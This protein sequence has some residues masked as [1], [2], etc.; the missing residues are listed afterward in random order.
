MKQI[1]AKMSENSLRARINYRDRID[2]LRSRV[3]LLT[4]KDKLL[5]TMCLE[6]GNSFRQLAQLTGVT[7]G[8]ISRRVQKITRRLMDGEYIACLRNR[9]KFTKAEL[10]IAKDYFLIG[11]SIKKITEKR[12]Y[13]YY[14]IRKAIKK[15]QALVNN[16]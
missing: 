15:I 13:T 3:S 10:D 9:D 6:H 5:M 11:L 16:G 8:C 2:L 1:H 4:G 12:C 14:A 7:N